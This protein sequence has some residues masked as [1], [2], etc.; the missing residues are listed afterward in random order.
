[1]AVGLFEHR[2]IARMVESQLTILPGL[3]RLE[4]TND[5]LVVTNG[6]LSS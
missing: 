1:M 2:L 4:R 5:D 6:D 3:Q